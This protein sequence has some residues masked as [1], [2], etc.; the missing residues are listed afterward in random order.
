MPRVHFG[1]RDGSRLRSAPKAT[2][3]AAVAAKDIW[4]PGPVSASGCQTSTITA[5]M[6]TARNVSALRSSRTAMSITDTMT[7][8]RSV[9][10]LPPDSAR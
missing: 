4:N 6:A 1:R 3:S 7:K 10:T 8:A 5:A 2:T 9:A